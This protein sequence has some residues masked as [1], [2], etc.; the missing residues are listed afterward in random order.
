MC[1]GFPLEITMTL[2]TWRLLDLG[3]IDPLETQTIYDMIAQGITEGES[4]NTLVICWPAKPLVSLGYF[5]EIDKDID[6]EFCRKN[7]IFVT[8]RV[9]GGGGVYLDDGQMISI[10]PDNFGSLML[11]NMMR[12]K[13]CKTKVIIG[14]WTSMPYGARIIEPGKVD[15]IIRI[16]ELLCD[17]L[18]SR[19]GDIFFE[20]LKAYINALEYNS[21][22]SY[23]MRDLFT[24]FSG[25]DMWDFF[26]NWVFTAGTP[27]YSLDS[28]SIAANRDQYDVTVHLKQKRKG[29]DFVG[30][31]NIVE[32]TFMDDEWNAY[33]D[34]IHFSGPAVCE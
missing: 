17:T 5:Q 14:G 28:F 15:C 11:R 6:L 32:V 23:D 3:P 16:R 22:T 31:S 19:D 21:A 12:E 25:I 10:F 4:E 30:N 24:S 26:E 20:T 29:N 33:M 2:E 13:G 9:I 27:H 1:C 8:R 34:T 7:D 18:P